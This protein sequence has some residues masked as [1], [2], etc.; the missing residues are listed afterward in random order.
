MPRT[1]GVL[2]GSYSDVLRGR[3]RCLTQ[4]F[5]ASTYDAV[6]GTVRLTCVDFISEPDYFRQS[7]ES[8]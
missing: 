1:K 6:A 4:T 7:Q 2:L 3:K 5:H 8:C